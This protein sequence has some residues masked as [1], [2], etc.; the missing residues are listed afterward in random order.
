MFARPALI[1]CLLVMALGGCRNFPEVE[2]S[3]AQFDSKTPYPEFVPLEVLMEQPEPAIT[4]EL[5]TELT[6][7]RDAL[8]ATPQAA[9]A[10]LRSDARTGSKDPLLNRL[11]ALRAKQAT[12]NENAPDIE[13]ELRKRMEEGI[14]PP[15]TTQ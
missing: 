2:V 12:H 14:T 7:R 4:P 3:E 6:T 1:T 15:T 10:V 5:Q 9:E 8:N 11:D 13:D